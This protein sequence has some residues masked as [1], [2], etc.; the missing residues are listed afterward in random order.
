MAPLPR[1]GQREAVAITPVYLGA[2]VAGVYFVM[3]DP[4][5]RR[6]GIGA[7]ITHAALRDAAAVAEYA[8]LGSSP[9]GRP[10]YERLGFR[11]YCTINF[12]EWSPPA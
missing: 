8:V 9:P 6:R 10:V 1:S 11:E 7:A 2:G 3:T 4:E 5:M 12:Y